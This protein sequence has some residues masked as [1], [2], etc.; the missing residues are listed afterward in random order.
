MLVS[1]YINLFF[2]YFLHLISFDSLVSGE[3]PQD[4]V[5][6]KKTGHL[7]EKSLIMKY[8][9]LDGKCPITGSDISEDDFVSVKGLNIVVYKIV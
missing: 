4:A 5:V 9:G 3:V 1:N 8:V 2:K 7:Y 6:S